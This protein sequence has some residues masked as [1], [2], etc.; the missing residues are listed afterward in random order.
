MTRNLI[1]SLNGRS[2]AALVIA[3]A[4]VLQAG[5]ALG[6][7]QPPPNNGGQVFGISID[8]AGA[9]QFRDRDAKAELAKVKAR[10]PVKETAAEA[11]NRLKF[12]SLVKLS[13]DLREHVEANKPL[14]EQ[15]KYVGGLTQIRYVL[16]YPEDKDLVIAGPSEEIDSSNPM[17]PRGKLTGR[18][19][20][21]LDDLVVAL[22]R[23]AGPDAR[24]PFGCSIDPPPN[25]VE[26]AKAVL[27]RVGSSDRGLLA[28]EIAREMGPQQVRLF[29]APADS[30]I[31]FICVAADYQL[32][33]YT[34]VVDPFPLAGIGH[35]ID[36]SR[37]AG[38][39]FWF[40]P[41]LDKLLV[42]PDG[43]AYEIRGQRIQLKAG[44]IPFDTKGATERAKAWSAKVTQNVPQL[45]AAVPLYADLQNI[46][47]VAVV[48]ALIQKDDLDKKVGWDMSWLMDESKFQTRSIPIPRTCDTIVNY[49]AGSLTAGGVSIGLEQ[50]I[51]KGD[52]ETDEKGA[53][54]PISERGRKPFSSGA[55]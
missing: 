36:N 11:D 28:R 6:Q 17:Q 3:I 10:R 22:R 53:L 32:K 2:L 40:E 16:V 35:P 50:L 38:N 24:K 25:A 31:A 1:R 20:I 7:Q 27:D 4:L 18:P 46:V 13:A 51:E 34:T 5:I 45:A 9:I 43:N 15:I 21:Q 19:I 41:M 29:G 37:P 54:T 12:L 26:R 55:K 49:A 52:R 8:P 44:A 23:A 39:G 33:R 48:G 14:P 42:A 30:R 47:D